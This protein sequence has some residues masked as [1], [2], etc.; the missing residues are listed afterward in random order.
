MAIPQHLAI[1]MDGNGR[2]AQKKGRPRSYGHIKGTRVAKQ[3]ITACSKRGVK[4][5]TLYAFSTENWFRPSSE[6]AL[7]MKILKRYLRKEVKNL[8]AENIRL[9]V[10]GE[11]G[12]L[13]A[14]VAA[15]IDHAVHETA[16]CSGLNL[17]FCLSYGS[18]QELTSVVR[19]FA[20]R[21]REGKVDPLKISE[22]DISAALWTAPAPNPDLVIR[23]SGEM[24]L[25]NFLLWQAAY[26][27]FWFTNILWPDFNEGLLENA[28]NDFSNRERRY[29]RLEK[30]DE[31]LH[32]SSH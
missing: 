18:R 22:Q 2:W 23:T 30:T 10:V 14:D 16:K 11:L 31:R 12:S 17:V 19:E 29:G 25:S 8:I 21:A 26:S 6:V 3:I 9:T 5:L 32:N 24:R 28:L 27:E 13:P 15:S 20:Q 7:L 4:W 1:I